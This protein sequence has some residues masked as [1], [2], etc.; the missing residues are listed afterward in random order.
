VL[1]TLHDAGHYATALPKAVQER[2][3]WQTAAEMLIMAAHGQRSLTFAQIAT[4]Q[5]L[6]AGKTATTPTPRRKPNE[7]KIV[8]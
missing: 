7:Y 3:E 6:H 8:R 1:K 5:A 2:S 4:L